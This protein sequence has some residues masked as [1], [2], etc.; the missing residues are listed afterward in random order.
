MPILTTGSPQLDQK[1]KKT[2]LLKFRLF[3]TLMKNT[4]NLNI[5]KVFA[6]N[7]RETQKV[8][9][10][11]SSQKNEICEYEIIYGGCTL[12]GNWAFKNHK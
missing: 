10:K 8:L 9:E 12:R 2:L 3:S 1:L 7:A 6:V 5:S 11:I 4:K